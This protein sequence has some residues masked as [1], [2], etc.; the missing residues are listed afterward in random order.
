MTTSQPTPIKPQAFGSFE[1]SKTR[2]KA[3]FNRLTDPTP[4]MDDERNA[5]LDAFERYECWQPYFRLLDTTLSNVETRCLADYVRLARVQNIYLDDSFAAAETAAELVRETGISYETFIQ[6]VLPNVIEPGDFGSEALLLRT[7]LNELSNVEDKV[8]N[9]ERLCMLYEKK[10]H[11]ELE[12]TNAYELLLELDRRNV[13]ALRFFKLAY[14]QSNDWEEVVGILKTLLSCARYPQEVYRV[15]QELAAIYLYQLEMPT[16]AIAVVERHCHESPLDTSAILFDA[17]HRLEKWEGCLQVL[18]QCLLTVDQ[19]KA[20]GVLHLKI[21]KL[22]KQLK[23][24]DSAY[25]DFCKAADLFPDLIDAVEGCIQMAIV[26]ENWAAVEQWLERLR[27]QTIDK[28][29]QSQLSQ[30]RQRLLDGVAS[31]G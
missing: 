10:V 9:L 23:R 28:T 17:Y 24:W 6:E 27:V 18:R 31:V 15:A 3:M 12:L 21:A 2:L 4:L 7:I 5:M 11:N 14:T 8:M 29:L 1:E 19:S 26:L 30:A 22:H 16:D 20:R 13:K 25:D